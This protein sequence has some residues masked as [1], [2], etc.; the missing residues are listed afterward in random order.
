MDPSLPAPTRP[1]RR[2]A[3]IQTAYQTIADKGFEGLRIRDIAAQVGINGATLHHYFPTKEA[4]IQAV[5]EYVIGRLRLASADLTGTPAELIHQHLQRLYQLMKSEP[6]LFV[7]L[8]EVHL[9]AQRD[10]I[11]QVIMQQEAY[12][13]AWL[14]EVLRA[15]REQGI[16]SAHLDPTQAASAIIT[17]VE[18]A[19]LWA[20]ALPQRIEQA[21]EQMEQW[22]RIT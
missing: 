6:T 11:L 19:G 3:L 2:H 5:V 17:L 22:L 7:V 16:W 14:V 10:P 15:G 13:H 9:R 18:G 12:W 4:L 8:T 21:I 20:I 1:D